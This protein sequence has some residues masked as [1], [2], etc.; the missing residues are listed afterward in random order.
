M[1]TL[2]YLTLGLLTS[3]L[4]PPYFFFPLG[5]IIFP[6]LCL[7]LDS[8][9]KNNSNL[10]IFNNFLLFGFGFFIS[11]LF[12]VKNPFFVF[13]ESKNLID[14]N[15]DFVPPE[16]CKFKLSGKPLKDK[17]IKVLEKLYNEK[18]I[19][20]HGMYVGAELANILSGGETTIEKVLSEDD[21]YKLELDSFMKLIETKQTQERIK[22]T[23][24]TGKPLVN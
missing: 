16:E 20:D 19:L 17:M 11:Y 14:Q 10:N 15:N 13:E 3:L 4:F 9:R 18:I 12:W 6:S 5:F 21:L 7:L 22:H 1:I 24:L 2:I 8:N 23:L